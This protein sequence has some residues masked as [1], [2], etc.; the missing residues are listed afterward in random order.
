MCTY[1]ERSDLP[2]GLQ[3]WHVGMVPNYTLSPQTGLP[4]CRLIST[5]MIKTLKSQFINTP[6][7]PPFFDPL[8]ILSL[9]SLLPPPPFGLVSSYFSIKMQPRCHLIQS[10]PWPP[11]WGWWPSSMSPWCPV[12]SQYVYHNH[13]FLFQF[14]HQTVHSSRAGA[15]SESLRVTAHVKWKTSFVANWNI[16]L[17]QTHVASLLSKR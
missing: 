9:T 2:T 10:L 12:P 16:T 17:F 13:L 11:R 5:Y 1:P 3:I 15:L 14:F 4:T 7:P 8:P 6:Q